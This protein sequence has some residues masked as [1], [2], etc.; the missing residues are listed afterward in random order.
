MNVWCKLK[1]PLIQK[2]FSGVRYVLAMSGGK[3]GKAESAESTSKVLNRTDN[4]QVNAIN[5]VSTLCLLSQFL[6]YFHELI[7]I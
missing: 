7:L 2:T 1:E 5:S 3:R 6:Q 4:L